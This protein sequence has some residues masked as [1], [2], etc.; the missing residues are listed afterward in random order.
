MVVDSLIRARAA[1]DV[2]AAVRKLEL[3]TIFAAQ[4]YDLAEQNERNPRA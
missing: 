4:A 2:Q 1:R 3:P